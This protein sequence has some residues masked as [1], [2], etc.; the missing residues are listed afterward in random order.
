MFN[1]IVP[2]RSINIGD[3]SENDAFY[4]HPSIAKIKRKQF[5]RKSKAK[6]Q[7][8][9]FYKPLREHTSNVPSVTIDLS[10]RSK[11]PVAAQL[12]KCRS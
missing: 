8:S 12:D 10:H 6:D 5:I 3:N 9:T 2:S 11:S 4:S 7:E 1:N